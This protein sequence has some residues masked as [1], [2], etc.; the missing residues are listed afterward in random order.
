LVLEY[1]GLGLG[2]QDRPKL[3][4]LKLRP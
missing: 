3:A 2:R 1:K 4:K